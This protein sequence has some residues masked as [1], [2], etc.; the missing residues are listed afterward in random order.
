MKS[1]WSL[2]PRNTFGNKKRVVSIAI[3]IILSM[4]LIIALSV[5]LDTF[6]KAAYERMIND[7]GGGYTF[8]RS[9]YK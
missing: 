4:C 3:S 2:I 7:V 6:K 5:M 8:K 1:F 9:Y